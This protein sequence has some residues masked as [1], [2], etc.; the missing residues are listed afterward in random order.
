MIGVDNVL[1]QCLEQGTIEGLAMTGIVPA[2]VGISRYNTAGREFSILISLFGEKNGIVTVNLTRFTALFL[3]SRFLG[4]EVPQGEVGED[5]LDAMCEIG[6]IIAGR[7]KDILSTTAYKFSGL[8]LP[9]LVAGASF[10]FYHYRGLTTVATE[11]EIKE[12]SMAHVHD[13]V[14]STSLALMGTPG[15]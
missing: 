14:F 13:R 2:P 12:I 6:N 8:S 3:A 9:A 4:E 5:T 7:F 11:F 1:L 10:S 15:K